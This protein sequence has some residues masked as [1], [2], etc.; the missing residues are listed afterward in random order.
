MIEAPR[1]TFLRVARSEQKNY[2]HVLFALIGPLILTA[3]FSAARI[4]DH[5]VAFGIILLVLCSGGPLFG[6]LLLPATAVF[7]TSI[8]RRWVGLQLR[9][10]DTAACIAYGLSPLMWMSVIVLPLQL[11]IFGITLFS[12]NP[13]A[14]IMQP[15]PFWMLT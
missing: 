6:L 14:W 8:L 10:R 15:L 7:M 9:Y 4:G 1:K 2:V 12:V 3:L 11:G 5:G 13:P